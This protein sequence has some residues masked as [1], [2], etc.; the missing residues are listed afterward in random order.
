MRIIIDVM[1]GDMGPRE[2]LKGALLAR[3]DWELDLTF[4]GDESLI[5]RDLAALR[6]E[7]KGAKSKTIGGNPLFS[8]DGHIRIV[9]TQDV[10]DVS[11][12]PVQAVRHKP[13]S[14]LVTAVRLGKEGYGDAVVSAGSTGALVASTLMI[15]GRV[16][17]IDRPAIGTLLPTD[18]QK[19]VLL[20]DA[21]ANTDVRPKNLLQFAWMGNIFSH[22][23]LGCRSP[24]I[25]LLNI[26]TERQKG[27]ETIKAAYGLLESSGLGFIGNIEPRDILV[28][29]AD[30]VVCDGFIGN[31]LLKFA[32]GV[33]SFFIKVVKDEVGRTPVETAAAF[34]L[35][36][37]FKRVARRFDYT[38][39][40][41][42]PILGISGTC[43]KCHGSSNYR[44]FKNGIRVA[45]DMALMGV[46]EEIALSAEDP[47]NMEGAAVSP[48]PREAR[49]VN[50][51][52]R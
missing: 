49:H 42:A 29:V 39:Y 40:G 52:E 37:G 30:V 6:P 17:A 14:S 41:G 10:I 24:R 5:E 23:V 45:K 12:P 19:N 31:A 22:K 32:E 26:G 2:V 20:I 34:L 33:G 43:I 9:H 4:V 16:P 35:R 8:N 44:A 21:G 3:Q 46:A 1:G 47:P 25:G 36:N 28:G 27:T 7:F 50:R 18:K 15:M 38:E 13:G 11:E 48:K 51:L